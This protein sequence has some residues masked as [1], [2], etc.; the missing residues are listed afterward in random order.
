MFV[1]VTVCAAPVVPTHWVNDSASDSPTAGFGGGGVPVPVS[2][3]VSG[4]HS[5]A[6]AT[7][8]VAVCSTV[9]VGWNTTPI[10]C[11]PPTGSVP[12]VPPAVIANERPPRGRCC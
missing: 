2:V 12:A 10:V 7:V 4:V 8:R 5:I 3:A 1:S 11:V 6:L 9:L